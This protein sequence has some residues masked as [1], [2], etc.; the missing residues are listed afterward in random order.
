MIRTLKAQLLWVKTFATVEELRLALIEWAGLY[1]E[2]W[3]SERPDHRTPAQTGRDFD[4][5][6]MALAA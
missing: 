6:E 2:L 3:L 4:V 1:R 5:A